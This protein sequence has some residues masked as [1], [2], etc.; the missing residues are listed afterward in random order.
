[1]SLIR[2]SVYNIAGFAIPTLV[3]IPALGILARQLGVE[4]FGLFTLAFAIV[5]YASIFDGG[6]TRAVIRE[7]A[8]FRD[9]KEE[10]K[11]IISTASVSVL[12][13]GTIAAILLVLFSNNLIS[14]LKVSEDK[15]IDVGKAFKILGLTLPIY[16]LNQIWLAYLEGHE[17]FANLNIQRTITSIFLAVLPLLM[18]LIYPTLLNAVV[19]LLI[20]RIISLTIT[21]SICKKIIIESGMIFY[22]ETFIRMMK[23][24]GWLTVS[25]IISPIMVYFDRFVVSNM[26][27]ASKVAFYSAPAEGVARLVNIPFALSRALFPKL[28]NS[29][30]KDEKKKLEKQSYILISIICLPIVIFGIFFSKFIMVTWMGLNYGNQAANV[31]CILLIGFYFNSLAQIP[32]SVLQA[33][34]KS[35]ITALIHAIEI[36]PYLGLLFYMTYHL[37][38]IG[39]AIAWSVRMGVDLIL[40][41]VLSRKLCVE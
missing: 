39:T 37:G 4:K 31:L 27:G 1:M 16:L 35:K 10:Q 19:G 41:F 14:F 38:L 17:K 36:F 21:F 13:F 11:K 40:L 25:N 24:G 29:Q 3:A 23:F 5:G 8:I 12:I 32:F 7:I 26:I 18:C 9:K 15:V 2:N 33:K 20:G 34:G 22:K 28:S 6:I 30:N